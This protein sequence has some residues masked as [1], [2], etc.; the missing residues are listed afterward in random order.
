MCVCVRWLHPWYKQEE[1]WDSCVR[2]LCLWFVCLCV[3]IKPKSN[4]YIA[5]CDL[6]PVFWVRHVWCVDACRWLR[7][8]SKPCV[9]HLQSPTQPSKRTVILKVA[10]WQ[11][12]RLTLRTS[13]QCKMCLQWRFTLLTLKLVRAV[14]TSVCC[15]QVSSSN[16]PR[17]S[18]YLTTGCF[19]DTCGVILTMMTT[20]KTHLLRVWELVLRGLKAVI[21]GYMN[22][23]LFSRE[24]SLQPH[25]RKCRALCVCSVIRPLQHQRFHPV[26]HMDSLRKGR[27]LTSTWIF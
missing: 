20:L 12:S 13:A 2:P 10:P 16:T 5:V 23:H 9:K 4:D 27:L 6:L 15:L 3:Y 25:A 18:H 14:D 22:T 21:V 24:K 7:V 1:R 17:A 19:K 8:I 11:M 26:T